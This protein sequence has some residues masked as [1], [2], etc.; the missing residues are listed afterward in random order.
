MIKVILE[1]PYL[2]HPLTPFFVVLTAHFKTIDYSFKLFVEPN[3]AKWSA[4][5]RAFDIFY[6]KQ[7]IMTFATK[8]VSCTLAEMGQWVDLD[9][10][11][12]SNHCL[13]HPQTQ[14]FLLREGKTL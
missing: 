2:P 13:A 5:Y 4:A 12:K 8:M 11:D 10:Q 3:I 6:F 1:V 9:K 7:V 14:M